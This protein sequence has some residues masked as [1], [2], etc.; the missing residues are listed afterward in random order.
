M[1]NQWT[2]TCDSIITKYGAILYITI[3]WT[4]IL[5]YIAILQ[6]IE[7]LYQ[8]TNFKAVKKSKWLALLI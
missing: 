8:Q 7:T 5:I 1:I 3:Y 6:D 4:R 2:Q